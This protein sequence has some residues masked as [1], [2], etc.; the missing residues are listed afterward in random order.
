MKTRKTVFF[1]SDW[2][3]GHHNVLEFDNRPFKTLEEMHVKLINNYN[4]CVPI[5]GIGYFLG[6]MGLC[7]TELLK[8]VISQLNGTKILI[9]GNHDKKHNAMY[10]VGFDCVLNAASLYIAGERVTLSHCP[11]RGVFRE[12]TAGMRNSTEGEHWHGEHKNM[13]YS[14]SNEGQFHLHGHCHKSPSE[15]ILDKQWDVG[16][17]ANNYRPVSISKVESFIV[18][19]KD[20]H[21]K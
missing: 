8:N 1:T 6:D 21:E 15:R 5:D 2:H 10:S 7:N 17:K 12:N 14:V 20:L 9:L 11:L 16:V 4:S 13:Q 18:R 19:Y 3:I